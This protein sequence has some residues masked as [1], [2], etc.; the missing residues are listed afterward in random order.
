MTI[1]RLLQWQCITWREQKASKWRDDYR[2][3]IAKTETGSRRRRRTIPVV[4]WRDWEK[5]WTLS[6]MIIS[7]RTENWTHDFT[8]TNSKHYSSPPRPEQFWSPPTQPPIQWWPGT[9]S[10]AVKRPGREADHSPPT[11]AEVKE[12]VELYFHSPNTSSWRG[13]QLKK[14]TWTPLPLLVTF[15][16]PTEIRKGSA[17]MCYGELLVFVTKRRYC[18]QPIWSR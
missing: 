2:L 5:T 13:T 6:A 17:R 10:L 8:N 16:S 12:C 15:G 9:L 14:S 1:R 11:S 18:R 3:W 4:S 7:L